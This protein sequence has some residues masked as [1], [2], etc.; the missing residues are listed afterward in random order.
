MSNSNT[1]SIRANDFLCG[2]ALAL[3]L[4]LLFNSL[5]VKNWWKKERDELEQRR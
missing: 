1:S 3:A 2:V 5:D 4:V